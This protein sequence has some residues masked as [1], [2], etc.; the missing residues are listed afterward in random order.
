MRWSARQSRGTASVGIS[1]LLKHLQ[2]RSLFLSGARI[3]A[4]ISRGCSRTGFSSTSSLA[5]RTR[6][7]LW[8]RDT[9]H[10]CGPSGTFEPVAYLPC[11]CNIHHQ[12]LHQVHQPFEQEQP[13]IH[14]PNAGA[15][16]GHAP[17]LACTP[18]SETYAPR[19]C[20][21]NHR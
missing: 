2:A 3:S 9:T 20:I 1:V 4:I 11:A 7:S 16:P 19:F 13:R 5:K 8:A 14:A 21:T 6:R 17:M 18:Y 12:S 15:I 10:H